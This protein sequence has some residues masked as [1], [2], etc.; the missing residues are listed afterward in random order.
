MQ[1]RS[2]TLALL[3]VSTLLSTVAVAD[4]SGR[5]LYFRNCAECHG[6]DATGNGP[7]SGYLTKRPANLRDG[8][9]LER[10]AERDLVAYV[11][12][13]KRLRLELRP[14]LVKRR[15]EETEALYQFIRRLPEM[16]WDR[17]DEGE[18]IFAER[19]VPCHDYYGGPG[20]DRPEGVPPPPDLSQPAFQKGVRDEELLERLRHGGMGMPVLVPRLT[21]AE[22]R[23]VVAYV[24]TLSP[25]YPLYDRYCSTCHGIRGEG[26]TG[27][28][29][30]ATAP[31]FAFD[32]DFF[33]RREADRIRKGIWHMLD[34]KS[35]SMPHFREALS[36]DEVK[37]ILA[38]LRKAPKAE[39]SR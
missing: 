10:Y 4:D 35:P 9:I 1:F 25:G 38:H 31:E 17:W 11:L 33:E 37:A 16:D 29:A 12:E 22:A 3:A 23:D 27:H 32:A 5:A 15:A 13:G 21:D 30:E 7:E 24:R 19:C 2:S 28:L 8:R 26:G 6:N 20:S 36:T 39:R 14:E 34:E 18:A